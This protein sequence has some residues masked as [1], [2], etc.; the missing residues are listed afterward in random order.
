MKKFLKCCCV[1]LILGLGACAKTIDL[2][3]PCPDYGRY[4]SQI[5]ANACD[6]DEI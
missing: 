6:N 4:C 2:D 1:L 3:A 5:P